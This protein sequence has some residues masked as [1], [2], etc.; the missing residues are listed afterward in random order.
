MPWFALAHCGQHR[1]NP[2]VCFTNKF[3]IK[4]QIRW[5]IGFSVTLFWGILSL[6]NFTKEKSFMEKLF[7]KWTLGQS[8]HGCHETFINMSPGSTISDQLLGLKTF[9]TLVTWVIL[10]SLI[11][12]WSFFSKIFMKNTTLNRISCVTVPLLKIIDKS[13][14]LLTKESLLTLYHTFI[15][16]IIYIQE[17]IFNDLMGINTLSIILNL[18]VIIYK[19]CNCCNYSTPVTTQV[20]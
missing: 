3:F 17:Y 16:H 20:K 6:Q 8:L 13:P 19:M 15:P 12:M 1:H 18:M 7:M 5:K 2:W 11:S 14:P 9:I 4:M 10:C